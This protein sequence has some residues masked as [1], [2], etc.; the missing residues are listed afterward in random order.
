MNEREMILVSMTIDNISERY[1]PSRVSNKRF[2]VLKLPTEIHVLGKKIHL[3][4]DLAGLSCKIPAVLSCRK[5]KSVQ[6]VII[7][8][9]N[10]YHHNHHHH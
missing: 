5:I 4:L 7:I 10:Y 3:L 2:S 9:V 8:T 1:W 6:T